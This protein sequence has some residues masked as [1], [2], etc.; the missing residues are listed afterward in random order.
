MV[1]IPDTRVLISERTVAGR[2][3][4]TSTES[5]RKAASSMLWVT[6]ATVRPFRFRTSRSISCSLSLVRVSSDE[7]GSSISSNFGSVAKARPMATLCLSPPL[8]LAG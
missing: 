7:K 8:S 1:F 6:I 3:P 5:P 4:R 2:P